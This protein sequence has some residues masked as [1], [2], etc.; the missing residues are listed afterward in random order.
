MNAATGLKPVTR[1]IL[2]MI[3]ASALISANDAAIKVLITQG[4]HSLEVVFLRNL[5]GVLAFLPFYW[6]LGL[7]SL[8]TERFGF[9]LLKN[10]LQ[11]GSIAC[12]FWALGLINLADAAAL[13]FMQPI[14]SSIGAI[15]FMGE[16]SRAIR[17]ICIVIGVAGMLILLSPG[18]TGTLN[19]GTLLVVAATIVGAAVRLM[20]K[21]LIRTDSASTIVIYLSVTVTVLTFIPSL[22]VWV[23][24]TFWQWVL[25]GAI[26]ASGSACFWLMTEALKHGDVTAI[27][28]MNYTRLV[29]AAFFGMLIFGNVPGLATWLGGAIIITGAIL[30]LRVET[31][32]RQRIS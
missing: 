27:E 4:F 24:P 30:L 17:W 16:R 20:T 7:H 28:P 21:N 5:F 8:R 13:G 2:Y 26:G 3:A 14:F 22:F 1:G 15:L 9:H 23:W 32:E 29:W 12:Y 18:L 10:V 31:R 25:F 11:T 19:L 6:R